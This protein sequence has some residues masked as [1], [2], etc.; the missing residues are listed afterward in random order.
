MQKGEY[1]NLNSSDRRYYT[2]FFH[3][4]KGCTNA[5]ECKGYVTFEHDNK[6][7]YVEL[8]K[9]QIALIIEN[10]GKTE[11]AYALCNKTEYINTGVNS[12]INQPKS[13]DKVLGDL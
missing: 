10:N 3:R 2:A 7:H 1:S 8:P 13:I 9:R 6:K 4:C 12:P 5:R 11:L